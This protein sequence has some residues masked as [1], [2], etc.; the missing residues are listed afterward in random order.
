MGCITKENSTRIWCWARAHLN[1]LQPPI[2]LIEE[3]DQCQP[4]RRAQEAD[5]WKSG[6]P[7]RHIHR[8]G[9]VGVGAPGY[10]LI[11]LILFHPLLLNGRQ[12]KHYSLVLQ[13]ISI[14]IQPPNQYFFPSEIKEPS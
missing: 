5:W 7:R 3:L 2:Q 4:W 11:P 14:Q 1:E 10:A 13:F 12:C 9:V 8:D 6:E